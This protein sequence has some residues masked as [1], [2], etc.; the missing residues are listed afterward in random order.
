[1]HAISLGETLLIPLHVIPKQGLL[2]ERDRILAMTT[3]VGYRR[4]AQRVWL[5]PS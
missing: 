5:M 1:M 4:D 2:F 3:T